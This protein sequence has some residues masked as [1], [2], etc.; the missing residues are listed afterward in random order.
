MNEITITIDKT[1]VWAEVAKAASYTGDKMTDDDKA[2]DRILM[3]DEDAKSLQRFW[4]E[5]VTIANGRLKDMILRASDVHDDYEVVLM[6]SNA[7][8]TNLNASVRASLRSFFIQSIVGRWYKFTNKQEA[9]SYFAEADV[10]MTDA[11]RKLYSRM[12]PRRPVR[13]FRS[14]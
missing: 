10:M 11:M 3:T 7:Y 4:E 12:R 8:D 2:Y 6:M 1:D 5:A 14:R 9:G 13:L